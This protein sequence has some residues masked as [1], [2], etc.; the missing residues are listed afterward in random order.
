[1]TVNEEI[2]LLVKE[3]IHYAVQKG[4]LPELA[5]PEVFVERTPRYDH[6]DYACNVAL[7][8]KRA[9]PNSNS[10]RIAEIIRQYLKPND[11]IAE[12]EIAQPGFINFRMKQGWL[13]GQV[14][15]IIKAG[16]S[17]G[18]VELGNQT[19]VQVEFVSANPTGPITIASARGAALGD[20]LANVLEAAGYEVE[21]EFYVN[22]A[23][24]RMEVFYSNCWYYYRKLQGEDATPP[25]ENYPAAEFAARLLIEEYGNRFLALPDSEG[26]LKVG[27]LGIEVQ[28]ADIKATLERMGVKF[29]RWFRE[30]S[31]F[32]SGEVQITLEQL[33]KKGHVA[34]REGAV[35]FVSSALGQE[36]DNVLI[37]SN[38]LPTYFVS[39][40]A[41]HYNKF[42]TRGFQ[43]VINIWGADHQGHIPRLKASLNALGLNPDDLTII[44]MQMVMVNGARMKKTTGNIV[45]L[46]RVMS[47]V[48]A[49]AIRY[50]LISRSQDTKIDFDLDLALAQS[51]ENP[52]YYVQYAHARCAS[53]F[54][55]APEKGINTWDDGDVYLLT[56]EGDLN[57]VRQLTLLPEIVAGAARNLEPHRLAFY[58]QELASAFHTYYHDNRV[59]DPDNVPLSKAR[60]LL[61]KA[62]KVT[63]ARVLSL[64]GMSAPEEL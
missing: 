20:A 44:V 33:R 34:E 36:K 61:V 62:V 45:T 13:A 21:R 23:G 39:D 9:I 42:I 24:S 40:I 60:L 51:N 3:A 8:L 14:L 26:R 2:A 52:V 10:M 64:M 29:N 17:Y 25:L 50:N 46:D 48:S 4:A 22:D 31:L 12:V 1:M 28:L 56:N 30:Q 16:Q 58:S 38:G 43:K 47:E 27:T 11:S 49:D 19:K 63:L 32:E 5:L 37:R 7:K 54:K 55:Q 6:G 15:E 59:I 35:W 18:N 53:I 57:L 41:Y